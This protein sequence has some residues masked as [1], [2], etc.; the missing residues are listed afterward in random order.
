MFKRPR[1]IVALLLVP[2]L[3]ADSGLAAVIVS[4]KMVNPIPVQKVSLF[5]ERAL[6]LPYSAA[7]FSSPFSKFAALAVMA[8]MSSSLAP[9]GRAQTHSTIAARPHHSSASDGADRLLTQAKRAPSYETKL[10]LLRTLV[11]Q[12]PDAAARS[13]AWSDLCYLEA[14]QD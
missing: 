7:R 3:L 14:A 9:F 5:G 6:T 10:H 8:I 12:D 11:A 2:C 1:R 4:P 13:G